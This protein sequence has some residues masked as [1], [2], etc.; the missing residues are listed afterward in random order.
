MHI[1]DP[2]PTGFT[3]RVMVLLL[4]NAQWPEKLFIE[5]PA[6]VE[7]GGEGGGAVNQSDEC[8]DTSPMVTD[9][10]LARCNPL[11]KWSIVWMGVEG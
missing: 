6:V 7:G 9:G 4:N 8:T 11:S 5:Q 1:I 10:V 2:T 3:V